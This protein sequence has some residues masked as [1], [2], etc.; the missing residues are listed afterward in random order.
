MD[1]KISMAVIRRMP[2][3]YRHLCEL[4]DAGAERISSGTLAQQMGQIGRA[5]V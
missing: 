5:H 1:K 4:Y 3:Y 2:R